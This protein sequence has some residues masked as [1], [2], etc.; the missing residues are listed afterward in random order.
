MQKFIGVEY[1]KKPNDVEIYK[2]GVDITISAVE[3]KKVDQQ[4]GETKTIWI[5]D[6]DRYM[7][8]EYVYYQQSK[9]S[10]LQSELTQSQIGLVEVYELVLGG[11]L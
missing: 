11:G 4:T 3:T 2:T 9:Y 5:C 10:T 8:L 6:I 7:L 1:D